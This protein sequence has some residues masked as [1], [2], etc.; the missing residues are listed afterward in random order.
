VRYSIE[1]VLD[2]AT[3]SPG[4]EFYLTIE[5]ARDFV[6]GRAAGVRGIETPDEFTVVFHL[7]QFDPLFLHKLALQFAAV[8]PRRVAE[9]AGPDFASHP[10]GSGPFVLQEWRRGQ[11][12]RLRRNPSYFGSE[13]VKIEGIDHAMGITEQLEWMKFEAG[14]LDVASIPAAEYPRVSKDPRY[15]GR[16]ATQTTMT[17]NYLGMN[18]ETPPFDDVR[19]RRAVSY[20][21]DREKALRLINRRGVPAKGILPPGMPG[22]EEIEDAAAYDPDR[23]RQLLAE[24]GH[25]GGFD[26]VLWTRTDEEALRLAQ[27]YQQDLAAVGIRAR[28][29]NLSWASFLE[30][31]RT[32]KLVPLF[33][34][35][36][37]ADFPDPSNFLEVLFHSK[38]IGSNN[39]TFLTDAE[40]DRLLDQAAATGDT[41]RRLDLLRAAHR[42]IV[43]LRPWAVLYH[44]VAY[45][46]LHPR[47]RNYRLHPLRPPRLEGVELEAPASSNPRAAATRITSGLLRTFFLLPQTE[48]QIGYAARHL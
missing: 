32:P 19:V 2:P 10:V 27:S 47:V 34:L 14:E 7:E 48:D 20:A 23:A 41:E 1:R 44:P 39:H 37:Q 4:A 24:A 15:R 8:V 36:W 40:L 29:K 9:A 22:Y 38:N 26:T 30:A 35:G 46:A 5:G 25:P 11:A 28:I 12:L 6:A 13:Q 31:V 18:C 17:T 3:R 43:A 16:M 21:I 45:A 33:L 42:R